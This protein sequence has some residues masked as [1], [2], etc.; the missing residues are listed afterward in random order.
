[1]MI[2][3][4]MNSP[5]PLSLPAL[6]QSADNQNQQ[7]DNLVPKLRRP[8]LEAKT[9]GERRTHPANNRLGEED[10]VRVDTSLVVCDV[11]VMDKQGEAV[12]GLTQDDFI[13]TEDD[14][15][16]KI[17]SFSLGDDASVARSIV[18]IIDYSGSLLPFIDLSVKAAKRLVNS[19]EAGDAMAIVTDDL[20]LL[21]DFTRDK[22]ELKQKLDLLKQQA[23]EPAAR[24]GWYSG[25]SL[26]FSA[27]LATLREMFDKE[28]VRPIIVFQTDGD[29]AHILKPVKEPLDPPI[30]RPF[31]LKDVFTEIEQ[32]RATIYSVVPGV[33]YAGLSNEEQQKRAMKIA[34]PR[35]ERTL[36]KVKSGLLDLKVKTVIANKLSLQRVMVEV[37]ELSGGWTEFLE[38]PKQAEAI[39]ARILSRIHRRYVMTYYPT[40]K[41][42]DGMRRTVRVEVRGHPE[43]TVW[44]RKS[45]RR[46]PE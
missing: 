20:T 32:S 24:R 26:Q 31:S 15:Q 2:L 18:L 36:S 35:N 33:R 42:A 45:Y 1:M 8:R 16:Q 4:G 17:A 19:L 40:N 10:V 46:T 6:A 34:N 12:R 9:T 14:T 5:V 41:G 27:L 39:Y 3:A 28:D 21:S 7:S 44:G 29:E 30:E 13:V 11:L 23:R 22:A 37:A 43:Y 38:E 25:H